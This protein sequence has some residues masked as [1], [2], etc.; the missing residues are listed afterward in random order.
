MDER[1]HE[2]LERRFELGFEKARDFAYPSTFAVAAYYA[3]SLA[4]S[5]MFPGWYIAGLLG[6]KGPWPTVGMI[7]L[8]GL[9][10]GGWMSS[11]IGRQKVRWL[12]E[13]MVHQGRGPKPPFRE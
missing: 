13:E 9:L 7:A 11:G 5:A 10:I 8:V 4:I 6:V 2:R 12:L 3:V 1:E